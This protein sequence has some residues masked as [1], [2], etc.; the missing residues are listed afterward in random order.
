ML[1]KLGHQASLSRQFAALLNL[2]SSMTLTLA[3]FKY[4]SISYRQPLGCLHVILTC[5]GLSWSL[6]FEIWSGE[7]ESAASMSSS[8]QV[9]KHIPMPS[10]LRRIYFIVLC[11]ASLSILHFSIRFFDI[12][13]TRDP[14]ERHSSFVPHPPVEI[15]ISL[16]HFWNAV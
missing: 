13:V 15:S 11:V 2:I 7:P 10:L 9:L 14:C 3:T 5:N 12:V 6:L 8:L 16:S 4:C 1:Q